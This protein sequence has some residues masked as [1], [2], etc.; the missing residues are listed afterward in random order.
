MQLK[1]DDHFAKRLQGRFGKYDFR[2]GILNDGPHKEATPA[3][4]GTKSYAGGPARRT[5]GKDSGQTLSDVSEAIRERLGFN[6]LS[7][8]FKNKS[9]DIVKFTTEFF[10]LA[11]G[12]SEK[13]RAENLLQAVVRNPILRGEYGRNSAVTKK[14][15][16]FDR[17]LIDT[18][19]FFK[20]IKAEC[21]VRRTR[22]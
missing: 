19:Q 6:Y 14:I 22:V 9:A 2:V 3:S 4:K 16:G 13:R 20:A 7:A 21:R 18:T 8:P 12:R 10:R 5:S 17:F 11:F 1:I 15:K